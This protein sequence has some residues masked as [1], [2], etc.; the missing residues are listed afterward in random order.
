MTI[1]EAIKIL[2]IGSTDNFVPISRDYRDAVE[3]GIEALKRLQQLRL[4]R[5]TWFRGPLP[6]ET[7]E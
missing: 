5:I 6:D 3:L 7:E 2:E 1:D 4:S